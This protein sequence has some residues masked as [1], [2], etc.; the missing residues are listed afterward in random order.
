M[1]HNNTLISMCKLF[2]TL[3]LPN[4]IYLAQSAQKVKHSQNLLL[5]VV[6][7]SSKIVLQLGVGHYHSSKVTWHWYHPGRV[8]REKRLCCMYLL[9]LH[10]LCILLYFEPR[11]RDIQNRAVEF[12]C[13]A[14]QHNMR[15]WEPVASLLHRINPTK[16]TLT[17]EGLAHDFNWCRWIYRK[18]ELHG[19]YIN[20]KTS[21]DFFRYLQIWQCSVTTSLL[22]AGQ[23][24]VSERLQV[25]FF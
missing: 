6:I 11:G 22:L 15:K 12:Y 5:S 24:R 9:L 7:G 25:S 13:V 18:L 19:L 17:P 2:V 21:V 3:R 1:S 20:Y 4:R 8:T 10:K 14:L 23:R 16:Q